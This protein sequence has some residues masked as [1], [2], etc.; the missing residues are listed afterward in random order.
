MRFASLGSGSSGNATLIEAD[1]TRLLIDC[2]FSIKE[3]VK[4]L[5]RFEL[6]PDD[7]DALLVT[8]EHG[9]HLSGVAPLARRYKFPVWMT[10]GTHRKARDVKIPNLKLFHAHQSFQIGSLTVRPFPVPH[11]AAEPCQFVFEQNKQKFGLLTDLGSITPFVVDSLAG[12]D[13][14]LLECNHD[15]DMLLTGPYPDYLQARVGGN[16]GHLE[17]SQAAD[18]LQRMDRSRLKK[19]AL[20]HLSEKNNRPELAL[21]AIQNVIGQ[22]EWLTVLDQ[23]QGGE[24]QELT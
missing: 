13:A 14:L 15:R 5:Q 9:D 20:G 2:G 19:L 8:H 1:G 12:C 3:T 17:N 24:W 10:H 11:D 7:L 6:T 21:A 18:L 23:Q 16:Y 22:P 4:R